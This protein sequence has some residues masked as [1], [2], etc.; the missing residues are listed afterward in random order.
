MFAFGA[1]AYLSHPRPRKQCQ[2]MAEKS[3]R[4]VSPRK[5]RLAWEIAVVLAVKVLLLYLIWVAW[6][7]QPTA[8]HMQV[9]TGDMARH[10]L[11]PA[12]DADSASMHSPVTPAQS[13]TPRR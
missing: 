5:S 6:F 8:R 2:P 10:M 3:Q 7:S 13:P 9:P 1:V 4:H 11:A 12:L